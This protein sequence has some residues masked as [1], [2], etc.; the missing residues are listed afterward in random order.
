MVGYRPTVREPLE[1]REAHVSAPITPGLTPQP[2]LS[3]VGG[4]T[5]MRRG[6]RVFSGLSTGAGIVI[7]L[8]LAAVAIFLF[9]E[10]FPALTANKADLPGG[11]GFL[12]YVW[13]LLFG[14]LLAAT[15]ALL[16]AFPL[17]V[18]I[19]LYISHYAP[20]RLAR[21]LGYITDLLAAIPSLVYGLWGVAVLAPYMVPQYGWLSK[22]LAFLPFFGAGVSVTG[23]TMATGGIVLAVMILPIMTAVNREVFLQTPTLHQEA[24]LALGATRWEMIRMSVIPY[25]RSGIVSGAMLGLGR[26]IGETIAFL[27]I[28]SVSPSLV[29]FNLTGTANPST[30]AANIALKFGESTGLELNALIATGLVLFVIT[31]AVNYAARAVLAR[32]AE[33]D[34]AAG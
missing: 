30:I 33:F 26:A 28:V 24:A 21:T 23:R 19:A 34:G 14:T 32:R 18:A 20:P 16:L 31:F 10:G 6:D 22:N 29:T 17:S 4:K 5:P 7:L 11:I 1:T 12:S 9:T 25:G 3:K 2:P 13:P 27:T 15:I 8:T